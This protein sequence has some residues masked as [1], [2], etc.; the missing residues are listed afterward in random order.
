MFSWFRGVAQVV[1]ESEGDRVKQLLLQSKNFIGLKKLLGQEYTSNEQTEFVNKIEK[2]TTFAE[3]E[4]AILTWNVTYNP[5]KQYGILMLGCKD[6]KMNQVNYFQYYV[7]ELID[8]VQSH[9][10]KKSFVL[11]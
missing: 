8:E 3:L 1:N 4:E 2:M 10:F 7:S 5:I 9:P 6:P 11:K